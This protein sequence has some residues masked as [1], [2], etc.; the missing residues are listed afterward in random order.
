MHLRS[1]SAVTSHLSPDIASQPRTD[2][3]SRACNANK[4]FFGSER[5]LRGADVVGGFVGGFVRGSP[6]CSIA[7]LKGF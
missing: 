3:R 5:S 7:L 6:L 2:D 1:L 4:L